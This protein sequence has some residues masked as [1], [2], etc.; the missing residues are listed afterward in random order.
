[1]VG[2]AKQIFGGDLRDVSLS[3][4]LQL[5]RAE[6]V[7]GW[8]RVTPRGEVSLIAG[9][10][11]GAACGPLHGVAA[12]RELL[13][14]D[15]G[16]FVVVRGEPSGTCIVEDT[17]A[18]VMDAYR[19]RDE[20]ARISAAVL[21]RVPS[22]P[23]TPTG[24]PLD[25]VIAAIDGQR[26]IAAVVAQQGGVVTPFVD[27]LI[28]AMTDGLFERV[29]APREHDRA[30]APPAPPAI[31]PPPAAP[32]LSPLTA[33]RV[34]T[35]P[36]RTSSP[37]HASGSSRDTPPTVPAQPA[38]APAP[39]P[40]ASAQSTEDADFFE[41]IDRG[42]AQM[43]AAEF[44]AAERTLRRALELRPGDRVALQNLRALAQRRGATV[45]PPK[46]R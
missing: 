27:A 37:P 12:L 19:L 8:I 40:I 36:L 7:S 39:A 46:R 10:V 20:W 45:E 9:K 13:F 22:R 30:A 42:R 14:L 29:R 34:A 21:R 41:L 15:A 24:G 28:A 11:V 17:T 2:L 26:T 25:F 33:P 4:L 38:P 23:W 32:S 1:M 31:P 44:D 5:A 16:H 6:A 35:A 3:S 18:V 43:R